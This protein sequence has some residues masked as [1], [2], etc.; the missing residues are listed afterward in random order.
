[1]AG[2]CPASETVSPTIGG[3]SLLS[4]DPRMVHCSPPSSRA[5][6]ARSASTAS[7][8]R[9]RTRS[10]TSSGSSRGATSMATST[11]TCSR[12]AVFWARS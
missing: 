2:S 10:T 3:W 9:R 7:S 12:R 1:M 8:A 4:T 5:S 6:M 11:P